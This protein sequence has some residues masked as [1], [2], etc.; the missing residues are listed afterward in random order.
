MITT[1]LCN[2]KTFSPVLQHHFWNIYLSDCLITEHDAMAW[3]DVTSLAGV[4]RGRACM[5]DLLQSAAGQGSS[6]D[7]TL[8]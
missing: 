1:L 4:C 2:R 5:D 6:P 3:L 8:H 7:Y